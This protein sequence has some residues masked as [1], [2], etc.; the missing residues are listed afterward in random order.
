MSNRRLPNRAFRPSIIKTFSLI[1]VAFVLAVTLGSDPANARVTRI[2][3]SIPIA[4]DSPPSPVFGGPTAIPAGEERLLALKVVLAT[5]VQVTGVT[6]AGQ[7]FTQEVAIDMYGVRSEI[8]WLR[9]PGVNMGNFELTMSATPPALMFCLDFF[10]GVDQSSPV[11]TS[12]S[13]VAA[14]GSSSAVTIN[15]SALG[16]LV[17]NTV[18]VLADTE[19]FPFLEAVDPNIFTCATGV[20]NVDLNSGTA[21]I[22]GSP[23][24]VTPQWSWTFPGATPWVA[25]AMDIVAADPTT[26]EEAIGDLA[27]HVESLGLPHG[28]ENA[29]LAKLEAARRSLAAGRLRA[30]MGQIGAFCNQVE[31]LRGSRLTNEQADAL[32]AEA[33]AIKAAIMAEAA[34]ARAIAEDAEAPEFVIFPTTPNPFNPVTTIRYEVPHPGSD[35]TLEVYDVS[36]RLVRHLVRGYQSPGLKSIVWD[37]RNDRGVVVPTGVYFYRVQAP[38]FVATRKMILMK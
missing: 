19:D 32:L 35:V 12:A 10:A 27:T 31:D 18:A 4:V 22:E 20:G 21:R 30:A 25:A 13:A 28:L 37:S 17:Y 29:L 34:A 3:G 1:I 16:N 9:D 33:A 6:Y 11:R 7:S 38:G 36:G 15:G 14:N 2:P 24:P 8:W 5:G 26:P 23:L